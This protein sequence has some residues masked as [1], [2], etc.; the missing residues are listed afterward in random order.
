MSDRLC[1]HYQISPM[2]CSHCLLLPVCLHQQLSSRCPGQTACPTAGFGTAGAHCF[3]RNRGAAVGRWST[4]TPP[5][6]Q[7]CFRSRHGLCLRF[8]DVGS[9]FGQCE[10]PISRRP[11]LLQI[12]P[13]RS[14][15]ANLHM[16]CVA[17]LPKAESLYSKGK[18]R[19]RLR[20]MW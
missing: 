17:T 16:Y 6:L 10:R 19:A 18:C 12:P 2:P 11:L 5:L 14:L 13:T 20:K 7:P 8:I 3:P 1:T 9:V 4:S 15:D